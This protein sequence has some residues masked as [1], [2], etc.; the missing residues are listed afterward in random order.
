MN[1][2]ATWWAGTWLMGECEIN[3]VVVDGGELG[4][5]QGL[6][7]KRCRFL[8]EAG[9]ASV[10]VNSCKIPTQNFFL[11]DMGLP[12]TV[13]CTSRRCFGLFA[14]VM[15]TTQRESTSQTYLIQCVQMEPNYETFECQFSFGKTPDDSTEMEA[16]NTPCL[17]RCP[18]AGALRQRHTESKECIVAATSTPSQ[19]QFM[20]D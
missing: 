13:S 4:K 3:D 7:V 19:C 9:C 12:L 16:I 1:A 18:T 11:Q 2:W 14:Y 6:L 20:E 17:A 8:E 15:I 10:C 5:D